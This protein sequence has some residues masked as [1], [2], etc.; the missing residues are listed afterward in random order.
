M[1]LIGSLLAA[2]GLGTVASA[3]A[4]TVSNESSGTRSLE[5][6]GHGVSAAANESPAANSVAA[7]DSRYIKHA[8]VE[9]ATVHAESDE[10]LEDVVW[11]ISRFDESGLQLP[12]VE[13]F[14]SADQAECGSSAA[15]LTFV[16]DEQRIRI[17][18]CGTRITLLHELGHAWDIANLTDE[19]RAAFTEL[20]GL[21]SWKADTWAEAAGEH[22]ATVIAWGLSERAYG[23]D[24]RPNDMASM[25]DGFVVLTGRR[26]LRDREAE[27][28]AEI[29]VFTISAPAS[30]TA[31]LAI[32]VAKEQPATPPAFAE[33]LATDSA[34]VREF[35][36]PSL[37]AVAGANGRVGFLVEEAADSFRAVRNAAHRDGVD[38][39]FVSAWRSWK[40]Q[41]RAHRHFLATGTNLA[42]NP[43]PNVAHP[44]NSNHPKGLALDFSIKGDV[45][46]WLEANADR[47][48][49]YPI[50]S[51]PWHWE[52]RGAP[53]SLLQRL[54]PTA[55]HLPIP[56]DDELAARDHD[57]I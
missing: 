46:A 5:S 42:G 36:K 23:Q 11:A 6:T 52:Y 21:D 26:P 13:I 34:T 16:G 9:L 56:L 19:R 3:E 1:L 45:H 17:R 51:E 25:Q 4:D 18:A 48:G 33:R 28:S 35:T 7:I 30:D 40:L 22:A 38:L 27:T 32:P 8:S 43:V 53:D 47:F 55:A 49:W 37:R 54:Q 15:Y 57:L 12:E 20:R 2:G 29:E 39:S 44:D 10:L 41:D 14:A 31:D 24:L 50:S